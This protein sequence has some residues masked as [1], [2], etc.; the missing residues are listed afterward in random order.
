MTSE[1]RECLEALC[2]FIGPSH[3]WSNAIRDALAL[4]DAR[5]M[6]IDVLRQ[7]GRV[8][9]YLDEQDDNGFVCACPVCTDWRRTY[10]GAQ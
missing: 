2:K 9:G 5:G 4:V 6:E 3:R 7:C 10:G 8:H 1:Q